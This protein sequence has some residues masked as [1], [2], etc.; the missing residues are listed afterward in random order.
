MQ[1]AGQLRPSANP[2]E[3]AA[4]K[5]PWPPLPLN[6]HS[7]LRLLERSAQHS[8]DSVVIFGPDGV[9]GWANQATA[10]LLGID[11]CAGLVGR[12][13]LRRHCSV[14]GDG[15][16]AALSQ[17][18]EGRLQDNLY[19]CYDLGALP[20]APEDSQSSAGRRGKTLVVNAQLVPL[21]D[22]YGG[23]VALCA[24]NQPGD[25]MV[26]QGPGSF[27]GP[28]PEETRMSHFIEAARLASRRLAHDFNNI[29]AVVQGYAD[30]L[31]LRLKQ[32]TESCGM[33]EIIGKMG[34]EASEVTAR[35]A[36]FVNLP[37]PVMD[38]VDL[39]RVV[40]AFLASPQ[41]A[42]PAGVQVHCQLA[43]EL[44]K[45]LADEDRLKRA[46]ARLWQNALD[47]MPNGG[48]V[49][50]RTELVSRPS[51][52]AP[53]L[54]PAPV[55][56]L[57]LRVTD[58]GEGMD[59]ATRQAMF[60]PFF[61]TKH[62]KGRGLGLTEVYLTLKEHQGFVEGSSAPGEGATVDLYFPVQ[63]AAEQA[64]A[65]PA[66]GPSAQPAA[67]AAAPGRGW[68]VVDDDDMVRLLLQH[69]LG[70]AGRAVLPA[71]SGAEALAIYR[72]HAARIDGVILDLNLGDLTG[73]QVFQQLREM[74]PQVRVIIATG[75]PQHPEVASLA[76]QGGCGVLAKPF[77]LEE[78]AALVNQRTSQDTLSLRPA[79]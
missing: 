73:A 40:E 50:W 5:T 12:L 35:L 15:A 68:L 42:A 10:G 26:E 71:A 30:L 37:A 3:G 31:K 74:D 43:A 62:G 47:A 21:M 69:Q 66:D 79:A 9:C 8:P 2:A 67:A 34:E 14:P 58:T 63:S 17:A 7:A 33:A 54:H 60:D 22:E 75:D 45:V 25:R 72:S 64:Q 57:R 18:L 6:R 23:L 59:E 48:S 32:D 36:A 77:R 51:Q 49:T 53:A 1:P 19:L 27:S 29:M 28:G 44:P 41:P 56:F 65:K 4:V 70:L 46:C 24:F 61:T 13:D 38:E 20:P 76:A 52:A 78:L 11:D 55:N 39:N 16:G